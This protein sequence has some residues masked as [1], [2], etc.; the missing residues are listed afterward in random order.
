M[1]NELKK[2]IYPIVI[3]I[4]VVTLTVTIIQLVDLGID[5]LRKDLGLNQVSETE[6]EEVVKKQ[7]D[8]KASEESITKYPDFNFFKKLTKLELVTTTPSWVDDDGQVYGREFKKFIK[9]E[10]EISNAYLFVNSSV[11]YGE[12]LKIWDSIYISLSKEVN[13]YSYQPLDGHLL[14]SES[15]AVPPTSTT[16]LLY[17]L[18][19]IP[20]VSIPY[21]ESNK[22]TYKNWLK[23]LQNAETFQFETF[24]STQRR[25]GEILEVSIGYE[26]D[27]KTPDC[28]LQLIDTNSE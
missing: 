23:L 24:L 8:H 4:V 28:R 1:A 14:R 12:P 16:A 2:I 18:S 11:D 17:S 26:C 27:T 3:F 20:F 19:D 9:T 6:I 22:P 21:S 5:W 13:G 15:L 25:G 7:I 10:G